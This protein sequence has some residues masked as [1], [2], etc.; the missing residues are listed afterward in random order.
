MRQC[1]AAAGFSRADKP[2]KIHNIMTNQTTC[3]Y[4]APQVK[5]VKMQSRRTVLTGSLT[6]VD[7]ENPFGGE[8]EDL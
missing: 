2:I 7:V 4:L 8:E 1:T 3:E 5:V 6:D